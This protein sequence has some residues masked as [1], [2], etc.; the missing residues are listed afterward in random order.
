MRQDRFREKE[1]IDLNFKKNLV[2]NLKKKLELLKNDPGSETD[3]ANVSYS[4]PDST[5]MSLKTETV[6]LY[7]ALSSVPFRLEKGD[8][9]GNSLFESV[10]KEEAKTNDMIINDL[11]VSN[12]SHSPYSFLEPRA[13]N[14]NKFSLP[15]NA[16]LL[17]DIKEVV[18]L[19]LDSNVQEFSPETRNELLALI[20][21]LSLNENINLEDYPN[22]GEGNVIIHNLLNFSILTKQGSF[23]RLT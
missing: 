15:N 16:T 13:T 10:F 19:I 14:P 2:K 20:R 4:D 5:L 1:V 7:H 17:R 18:T 3:K 23:I 21:D 6:I 9:I 12:T 11:Q 8:V 22:I